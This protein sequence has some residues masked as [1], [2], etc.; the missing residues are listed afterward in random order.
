MS[1]KIYNI[2]YGAPFLQII[3]QKFLEDYKNDLLKLSDVLFLMPNRRSCQNLKEAFLQQNGLTPFLL[4]QI[5]AVQDVDEDELFFE[6]IDEADL[7]A[8]ISSQERLFLFAK[9]IA[10]KKSD[11]NIKDISFAQSLSLASDLGKLIDMTYQENLSFDQLENIVPSEYAAHWQETLKFLKIVT[12]FWPDILK[13]RNMIDAADRRNRLLYLRSQNFIKNNPNRK[14]VAAGLGAPFDCLKKVLQ[15]IFTLESGEIYLYGLDRHITPQ[16]WENCLTQTHPQFEKKELLK[17]LNLKRE[18]VQDITNAPNV[19]RETFVSELMREAETTDI[20]RHVDENLKAALEGLTFIETQD[21]FEEA[22]SICLILREVLEQP[23][24]TAALVTTDRN[25]ARMVADNLKRFGIEIDDSAGLPL[26]LSPIGIFLR[27]ILDVLDTHFSALSL[28]ALKKNPYVCLGKAREEIRKAIREAE[29]EKRTPR[30]QQ[31]RITTK[32]DALDD[33]INKAFSLMKALYAQKSVPFK[34]LLKEHI[35]LAETLAQNN[36]LTGSENLWRHADGRLCA[37]TLGNILEKAD[38]AGDIDPLQY[39]GAFLTLLSNQTVRKPYGSHPRLKI[40]G[41]IEARF[42][43]FDTVIIGS[44][45][46]G[47][48]P[49][50]NAADPFMSRPMKK[51]FGLPL[52]E[53]AIGV[54]ADDLSALLNA[55][56][57]FVTRSERVEGTPTNKSRYWLRAETL[58]KALDVN[59]D[60]ISDSFYKEL[61]LKIDGLGKDY[62]VEEIKP[63]APLVPLKAKPKKFSASS[64]KTLM[65]SPYDIYASKVLGLKALQSLEKELDSKDFGTLTHK[66]LEK[67][68]LKYPSDLDENAESVLENIVQEE[69]DLHCSDECKKIFWHASIKRVIQF[70]L[71][72]EEKHRPEIKNITTEVKGEM[73]LPL[74]NGTATLTA[75]AD[76]I[77]ETKDGFYEIVD[78]KTGTPPTKTDL[79]KGYFPQLPLEALIAL[80][81]GFEKN[82]KKLPAKPVKSLIY[83]G[84][85]KETVCQIDEEKLLN[86]VL[87]ETKERIQKLLSVFENEKTPYLFNP[88]PKHKNI[89]SDYEH[90]ARFKEWRGRNQS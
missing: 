11:Y 9:M 19:L 5:V 43:S 8:A 70:I 45:N 56:E 58:L 40:L 28:A 32:D 79:I 50:L 51:D 54:S 21:R 42:C 18:D 89:Y 27:Q 38:I 88:N 46:E 72:F 14:I 57:V 53:R 13:Q 64:L 48:W 68:S 4:P 85:E 81:G 83:L 23:Q 87:E 33:E 15:A 59:L 62:K 74:K 35:H 47:V 39:S 12:S 75:T 52:P 71:T 37:Q 86:E 36:V 90:L 41:P 65:E 17:S 7:P 22:M 55:K 20:W 49:K 1:G 77:N 2:P 34:D 61:G 24:K 80:S 73:D 30:Y 84:V 31:D 6:N 44:L 66:I 29:L 25:L 69:L 16:D 60:D 26:H 3:A 10:S 82:G 63:V 76:R 78:Y 67:F